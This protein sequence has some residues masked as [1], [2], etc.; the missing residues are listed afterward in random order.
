VAVTVHITKRGIAGVVELSGWQTTVRAIASGE[1]DCSE[2]S[3]NTQWV[4]GGRYLSVAL[5]WRPRQPSETLP[6][7]VRIEHELLSFLRAINARL[8]GP[9][10]SDAHLSHRGRNRQNYRL[11]TQQN[12]GPPLP[13]HVVAKALKTQEQPFSSLERP[14]GDVRNGDGCTVSAPATRRRFSSLNYSV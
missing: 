11:R 1:V 3:C 4:I 8:N 9:S 12:E 5:S 2:S 6:G 14:L 13:R 10:E 7:H